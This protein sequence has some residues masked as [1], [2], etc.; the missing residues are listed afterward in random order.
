MRLLTYC[1][2]PLSSISAHSGPSV[3]LAIFA[4]HLTSISSL[5]GAINFIVT[6]LN[7]RSIGIH[8]IDM[9]LYVWAI[10]FTAILLLL[11]LPVLTAGVT[12][13]L[14]DRNFNTGF[15]EVAAGGDPILYEHLF[16]VITLGIPCYYFISMF[17]HT[18][19]LNIDIKEE[20]FIFTKFYQQYSKYYPNNPLPSEEFL[21]WFIGFFEGDG[22]FVIGK[23]E[24]YLTIIQPAI[25]K[26]VLTYIC[27]NLG[28]GNIDVHSKKNNTLSWSIKNHRHVYLLCLLLNGNIVLPTRLYQLMKFIGYI[29]LILIKNNVNIIKYKDYIKR[30]SL[31]DKWLIGYTDAK[32]TFKIMIKGDKPRV[33]YS[34]G[35]KYQC[36]KEVLEY[37]LHLFHQEVSHRPHGSF[38][39]LGPASSSLPSVSPHPFTPNLFLL[40]IPNSHCFNI[41][42]Y[43]NKYNLITKKLDIYNMF[44]D[45]LIR[46]NLNKDEI[47]EISKKMNNINRALQR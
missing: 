20:G 27:S 7:M 34:I 15:Y 10:F 19:L 29:N 16:Y 18:Y 17:I 45:I 6:T 47:K 2:P 43:F 24:K 26:H 1:Y 38:A 30:P 9:P 36:N 5:L 40:L 12:L 31:E 46:D 37:V 39:T 25:N 33:T 8:M 44:K 21:T 28:I 42:P 13:L 32:G 22:T 4:I 23:H 41:L 35:E 11:S 14:M 3:D